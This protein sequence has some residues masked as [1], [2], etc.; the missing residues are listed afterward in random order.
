MRK[1]NKYTFKMAGNDI[2][3]G[4]IVSLISIP[5]SM[6]YAQIAG[7]P[8]VYGL[9]GS[10]IPI[11]VFALFTTTKDFVFGVDAAPA[12]LVGGAIA[13]LG[14]LY[15][16][17]KSIEIVPIITLLVSCWLFLFFLI[18]AGK[19]VKYI[20][21]A[22]MGGFVSG[23]C[24]EIIMMQIPKLFGGS[25]G[26]G[27]VI[28]LIRHIIHELE[29]F[30]KVSFIL[31]AGTLAI[32]LITKKIL[33]KFPTQIFMMGVGIFIEWKFQISKYD[34]KM[35]P[36]V[37]AGLPDFMM[38]K[39]FEHNI[40]QLI[41][42]SL[43][44]A[45]VI[46]AES[47]L[48][49]RANAMNDDY[50]LNNNR[51]I[52]S[53]AMSNFSAMIIGCCPVNGS[54]SRTSLLR[55]FGG[56]THIASFVAAGFM[57]LVICF[58]TFLIKYM[59]LPILTAIV[60]S[61]LISATEFELVEKFFKVNKSEFFI[62]WISFA[63]VLFLGTI[64]GVILGAV[65]SFLVVAMRSVAPPRSYVGVIPGRKGFFD[66]GRVQDARKI[67]D[68]ILYRFSGNLFFANISILE[69]DI[70]REIRK[71]TKVIVVMAG[72]I[73]NIDIAAA[74]HLLK[75]YDRYKER[76]IQFYM[77]DHVAKVNDQLRTYGA[78][79]LIKKGAVRM[80]TQMA[81]K[82]AGY[83]E[84]YELEEGSAYV[85]YSDHESI[86]KLAEIEWAY[87]DEAENKKDEYY[88]KIAKHLSGSKK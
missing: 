4:I 74:E 52:F 32:I 76:G 35:L 62:F 77:T 68:V 26:H 15:G 43:T 86:D 85:C 87:G 54:V 2:F 36:N 33:P 61:A 58:G 83:E 11:I 17:N 42:P 57:I 14:V 5:I 29:H 6:G 48:A 75:L 25:V 41:F 46:L 3:A 22:V 13:N 78:E 50:K 71:D 34:V 60:I 47:L 88:K 59:P 1:L 28:E 23:I 7:I 38:P 66:L 24:V 37:V 30:N 67:N 84:P 21:T 82:E 73:G 20:S 70:E 81:L 63:G 72:G 80:T 64:K 8:M 56:K 55:R 31:G 44:I 16:G 19:I 65:L 69:E 10:V 9:Y 12:A 51:E 53:Y 27:E 18:K 79:R 45:I 40:L 49:S 39:I